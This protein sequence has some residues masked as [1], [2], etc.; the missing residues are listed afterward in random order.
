M[1]PL[2]ENSETVFALL[3]GGSYVIVASI[4]ILGTWFWVRKKRY[5]QDRNESNFNIEFEE[6][7]EG[8]KVSISHKKQQLYFARGERDECILFK[9]SNT[10]KLSNERPEDEY[11]LELY[12]RNDKRI[13]ELEKEVK[14]LEIE[15]FNM[16][17]VESKLNEKLPHNKLMVPSFIRSRNQSIR[18]R[19][20]PIP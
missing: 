4:S 20:V 2:W 16:E 12:Q 1:F 13:S 18:L 11:L 17:S 15:I 3:L 14:K 7:K 9:K 19:D 10:S 6:S 8:I 5:F